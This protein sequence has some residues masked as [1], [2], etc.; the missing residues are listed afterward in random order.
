MVNNKHSLPYLIQ[1]L[2]HH[3]AGH[4]IRFW[5]AAESFAVSSAAKKNVTCRREKHNSTTGGENATS[6][7]PRSQ[8]GSDLPANSWRPVNIKVESGK[9][10][11]GE[12]ISLVLPDTVDPGQGSRV[13]GGVGCLTDDQYQDQSPGLHN[14]RDESRLVKEVASSEGSLVDTMRNTAQCDY[15]DSPSV[16]TEMTMDDGLRGETNHRT[17][18]ESAGD[19]PSSRVSGAGGATCGDGLSDKKNLLPDASCQESFKKCKYRYK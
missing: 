2:D 11:H 15:L 17:Q 18:L 3:N 7:D 13:I 9:W 12:T 5:L 14:H 1:Y 4:L 8:S 10:S 6:R 19:G 16:E